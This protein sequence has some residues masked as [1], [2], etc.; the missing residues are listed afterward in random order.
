MNAPA[1]LLYSI[2]PVDGKL[3]FAPG[4]DPSQSAA[5]GLAKIPDHC[6]KNMRAAELSGSPHVLALVAVFDGSIDLGEGL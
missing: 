2:M 6:K 1:R 4:R 3:C 5:E